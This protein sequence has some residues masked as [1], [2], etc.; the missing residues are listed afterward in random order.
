MSETPKVD[1]P[2]KKSGSPKQKAEAE[3]ENAHSIPETMY[4]RLVRCDLMDG[5]VEVRVALLTLSK[6]FLNMYQVSF[7]DI[8]F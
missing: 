7:T 6:Y 8:K 5:T 2:K 3:V 4:N 1:S